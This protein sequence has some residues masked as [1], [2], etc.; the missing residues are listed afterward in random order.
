MGI[1]GCGW[2]LFLLLSETAYKCLIAVLFVTSGH[3]VFLYNLSKSLDISPRPCIHEP[4][5][6][7]DNITKMLLLKE[8]TKSILIKALPLLE[9]DHRS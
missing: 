8:P 7:I 1:V 2:F 4:V 3:R 6:D 5:R 9:S